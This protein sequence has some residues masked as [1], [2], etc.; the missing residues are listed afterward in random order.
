MKK[1]LMAVF[2]LVVSTSLATAGIGVLWTISYGAYTHDSP[3]VTGGSH[4][5][6]GNYSAIWQL[7]YAGANNAI[8]SIPDPVTSAPSVDP[9][10]GFYQVYG[11]DE[12]LAERIIAQG[13]GVAGDGTGWTE[14]MTWDGTGSNGFEDLA[15]T[16][17]GYVYQRVFEGAP[18]HMSWYYETDLLALN[19]GFSGGGAPLQ[20]FS[21][22]TGSAGFQPGQQV[23]V[24]PEPATMSLL[25]LG[26]LALAIR[27]RRA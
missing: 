20:D 10:T 14:W 7:I 24:I 27:R 13:G 21:I 19:T 2:A 16:T 11:D 23:T 8:D 18:G 1:F 22:D 17:A 26:A 9:I 12:V 5:L 6:L 25:G 3:D 15:W 4:N